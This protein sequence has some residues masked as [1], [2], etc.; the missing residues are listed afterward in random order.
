MCQYPGEEGCVSTDY[1]KQRNWFCI[2]PADLLISYWPELGHVLVLTNCK[3]HLTY[4]THSGLDRY[5]QLHLRLH[6]RRLVA[7]TK[8][9]FCWE[10]GREIGTPAG[11]LTEI[12]TISKIHYCYFYYSFKSM[13]ALDCLLSQSLPCSESHDSDLIW[14]SQCMLGEVS[15]LTL[16]MRG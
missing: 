1:L 7:W 9:K 12:S 16:L 5:S 6:G 3:K 10:R 14:Y 8:L 2:P 13:S 15:P 11:H 4:R